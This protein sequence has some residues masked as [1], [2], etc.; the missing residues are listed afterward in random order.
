M[1]ILSLMCIGN[2]INSFQE[3]GVL[4]FTPVNWMINSNLFHIQASK[5]Y[6]ISLTAFIA[7]CG[8]LFAKQFINSYDRSA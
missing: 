3:A 4:G 8:P 5:E 6:L 2:A 1:F 7:C